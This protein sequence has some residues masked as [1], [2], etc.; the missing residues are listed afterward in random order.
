[1]KFF[2]NAGIEVPLKSN[3]IGKSPP[4]ESV[5]RTLTWDNSC[6]ET[7]SSYPLKPTPSPVSLG[8]EE[9]EKYWFSFVQA[10]LTAAGLDC[11]VQLDSFFSR[12]HSPESPLD[13][14]LRDKY[15]NPNDKELLHEAKRRQ[16]R[17]NQKLVFDSVN[18]ALVEITG[19]GS[20]RSTRAMT[21]S[22][23]QN[24]LVEDAQPMVAEYVWA[25]MK[26]WFCSDVRCASGDGGGDSNSL[27]VEM[28]VRKEVVGKGWIDKMRVELDTLQ[29]EIEGKLL[30]ELVEETVIDF[31]G[32]M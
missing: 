12:W 16:R 20:D 7:A 22:G 23:V 3:L 8:A 9:D 19:H 11:E 2:F 26:E 5:A 28:V 30:D 6:A 25:Q 21:S 13:P 32:R 10:L 18:A 17:S 15:A 14:S 24:R 4:I 29:N 27:V 1:M 31:A